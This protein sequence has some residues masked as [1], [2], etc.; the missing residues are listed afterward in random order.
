MGSLLSGND[1]INSIDH[2]CILLATDPNPGNSR[3]SEYAPRHSE[4]GYLL[5][6]LQINYGL[7]IKPN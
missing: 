4:C 6:M 3:I 2:P 1:R 7:F 5:S